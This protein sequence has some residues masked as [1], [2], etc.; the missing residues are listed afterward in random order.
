MRIKRRL[1]A[2]AGADKRITTP[3]VRF[4]DPISWPKTL[5]PP[6]RHQVTFDGSGWRFTFLGVERFFGRRIDWNPV[7]DDIGQLWRMNLHYFEYLEVLDCNAGSIAIGQWIEGNPPGNAV[8]REA[9]WN[10]YAISLRIVCWLQWLS[11]NL[12]E[13]DAELAERIEQSL[14]LQTAYLARFP[15]TDIGGN[16][17]IKNVKALVWAYACLDSPESQRWYARAASLLEPEI[18][19]Q[20]LPDGLHFELSPSYHCQ[21]AADFIEIRAAAPGIDPR[22]ERVIEQMASAAMVI[23][24]PD[25]AVAQFNDAGLTMAYLP[26]DLSNAAG[27]GAC[28]TLADPSCGILPAGGLASY[29]SAKFSTFVKFGKPGPGALPAHAHGDIGTFELSVGSHRAIVD[30]GV[31]EYVEGA[32]RRASRAAGRHNLTAPANGQMADFF[33][34]FRCG[35]MPTPNGA[36]VCCED[37]GLRVGVSHDGFVARPRC[38]RLVV[39]RLLSAS[40]ERVHLIDR[41]DRIAEY[42]GSNGIWATRFLLHPD[43]Q[44]LQTLG[45]WRLEGP[46]GLTLSIRCAVAGYVEEAEW[47]PDMGIRI[48]TRRLVFVWE[49]GRTDIDIMIELD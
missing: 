41:C 20:V 39:E 1:E 44:P 24:H 2:K 40:S 28:K 29:R 25:G 7:A 22:L 43:W 5:F 37:Q 30:Q 38:R 11:R 47:W 23:A 16:H 45:G 35:W 14:A 15:E 4:R 9:G 26:T 33:G 3:I 32:Q 27:I 49:T 36:S 10:P 42:D 13:L 19:T 8:A 17:L 6:R 18:G 21:V 34:A 12:A 48:A 46:D 31:F